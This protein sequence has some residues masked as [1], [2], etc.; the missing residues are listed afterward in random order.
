MGALEENP[1]CRCGAG[2]SRSTRSENRSQRHGHHGTGRMLHTRPRN[3][4]IEYI[5]WRWRVRYA[6][7]ARR[8]AAS[9]GAQSRSAGRRA[10]HRSE[11]LPLP[12]RDSG[13]RAREED[14]TERRRLP[15]LRWGQSLQPH[16]PGRYHPGTWCLC[17]LITLWWAMSYVF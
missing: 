7:D 13:L 11:H 5:G 4:N 8:S 14:S 17:M 1:G 2:T 10:K 12:A 15:S 3:G 9:G 6:P 16:W